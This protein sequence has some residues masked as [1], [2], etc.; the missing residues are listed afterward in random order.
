M[1]LED[2][3]TFKEGNLAY[4]QLGEDF[5]MQ[6]SQHIVSVDNLEAKH[7]PTSLADLAIAKDDDLDYG[8]RGEGLVMQLNDGHIPHLFR[9][10]HGRAAILATRAYP[11][12]QIVFPHTYS[13]PRTVRTLGMV[14]KFISIFREK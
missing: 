4:G 8:S 12:D 1:P 13:L 3:G 5:A 14:R 10:N 2:P 9:D 7:T 6:H 11:A